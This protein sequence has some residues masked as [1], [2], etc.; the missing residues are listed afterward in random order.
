[1]NDNKKQEVPHLRIQGKSLSCSARVHSFAES[2]N[3][4]KPPL[5]KT[6]LFDA[7]GT[8]LD[9]K[10]TEQHALKQ[11]FA[12]YKI[13]LTEEIKEAY[14]T[15]NHNLW[16][17][18]EKGE[19]DKQTV[20]YTRFCKLFERFGLLY[21]GKEFEDH[22]QFLL[23]EGHF[24]IPGA[25]ELCRKLSEQFDLYIV[26]NGVSRTQHSRLNA[27]GLRTYM[28]DVFVSEDAGYQKP[29]KKFFDYVFERIPDF[30]PS[31]TIIVGDS[32]TSDIQ[33]G[34]NAGISTCWYNPDG[35][36]NVFPYSADYEIHL[37]EDLLSILF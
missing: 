28:K 13:S 29:M 11:C 15:I 17:Q 34:K 35:I 6:I 22:Y 9:F 26:S 30:S 8:L 5:F 18:F 20:V 33:G 2:L 25:L 19:I 32:L 7:D 12:E 16:T 1:M 14:F 4:R 37:L 27:S 3:D 36:K 10:K 21:D 31:Q 23:G 24:L